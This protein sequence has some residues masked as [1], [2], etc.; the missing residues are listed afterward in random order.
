[1]KKLLLVIMLISWKG[2][3]QLEYSDIPMSILAGTFHGISEAYRLDDLYQP[4]S[5]KVPNINNKWHTYSAMSTM[6][7]ISIPLDVYLTDNNKFW[8]KAIRGYGD[9]VLY[10][11]FSDGVMNSQRGFSWWRVSNQS[12]WAFEQLLNPQIKIFLLASYVALRILYNNV[13]K[14]D[15]DKG[16]MTSIV[17]LPSGLR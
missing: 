13:W 6:V 14:E 8:G 10:T 5:Q 9:L 7:A 12:G 2:F 1:M 3:A 17:N 4:S 11:I 16:D 15:E